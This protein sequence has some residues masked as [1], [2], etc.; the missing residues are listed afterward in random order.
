[1]LS[2]TLC[3]KNKSYAA[4][5]AAT[6]EQTMTMTVPEI[7][8]KYDVYMAKKPDIYFSHSGKKRH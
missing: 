2:I 4:C 5:R 3:A 1:M 7:P 8:R 6:A